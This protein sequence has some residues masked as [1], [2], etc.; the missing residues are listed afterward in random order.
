MAE[1]SRAGTA[2]VLRN[3]L[4]SDVI[5]GNV[6]P[7]TGNDQEANPGPPVPGLQHLTH[8]NQSMLLALHVFRQITSCKH[9]PRELL[10]PD[11]TN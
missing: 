8:C 3:A 11:T 6:F 7:F 2:N 10:S 1:S 9:Y 5:I 4:K